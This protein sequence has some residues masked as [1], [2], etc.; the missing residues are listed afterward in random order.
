MNDLIAFFTSPET[1]SFIGLGLMFLIF[2]VL[3]YRGIKYAYT[4]FKKNPFLVW[5]EDDSDYTY[6]EYDH[7]LKKYVKKDLSLYDK[8]DRRV[9]KIIH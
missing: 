3:L 5:F 1:L 6:F 7:A 9:Y 8:T 4:I 2:G